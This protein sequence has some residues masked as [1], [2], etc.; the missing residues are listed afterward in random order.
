M[1]MP[2]KVFI[3]H[4]SQDHEFVI[5]LAEK[6]KNDSVDVWIDD[7]EIQIGDSITEK[8]NEGLEDSSFFIIV[9]SENSINSQWVKR[10]LN[11]TLMTQITKRDIKILPV[12]LDFE[13]EN[14]PPLM[15]DIYS[16]KFS[17]NKILGSKRSTRFREV[18]G[19][20]F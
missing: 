18:S 4:S 11:A 2:N 10:E 16:V 17:K 3:C 15:I 14:L 8:I 13:P 1:K 19:C 7:W 6:L 12:L 9:F 20:I 5:K